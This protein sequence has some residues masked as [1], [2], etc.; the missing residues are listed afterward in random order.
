MSGEINV[1]VLM[2]FMA[3]EARRQVAATSNDLKVLG[4][5]AEEAGRKSTAAGQAVDQ[6]GASAGNAA[7]DIT[8]AGAAWSNTSTQAANAAAQMGRSAVSVAGTRDAITGLA[9]ASSAAVQ[10]INQMFSAMAS[11]ETAM[12][13]QIASLVGIKT[14]TEN[15]FTAQLRHGMMLDD[16]RAKFNPLFAATRQYEAYV[17]E[18]AEAEKFGA[19]SAEEA[20]AA[21]ERARMAMAKV[22]A[23]VGQYGAAVHQTSAHSANLF[24][25]WNDIA[26]MMAAGQNPMQLA[27]QQG[28]QVS[29]VLMQLGGGTKALRAVGSSFLAM[30]NPVSLATI[31]IIAFGAAGVKWLMSL[32]EETKN[33]DDAMGDLE[34]TLG[35]LERLTK[36]QSGS[37]AGLEETYGAITASV[38]E[39]IS[40]QV[41]LGRVKAE[42]SLQDARLAT[43][44]SAND[45]FPDFGRAEASG[46][47]GKTAMDRLKADMDSTEADVRKLIGTFSEL[48]N[49]QGPRA[50]ADAAAR[51]RKELL[52]V[53][54][55]YDALSPEQAQFFEEL[56]QTEAAARRLSAFTDGAN[57]SLSRQINEL[58]RGYTQ[59]AELAEISLRFGED[60]V[61]VEEARARQARQAL[62]IKLEDLGV[63]QDS[64]EA[65]DASAA[66]EAQ[67][68]ADADLAQQKRQKSQKEY[69]SDLGRQAELSIAIQ[70]YG[71][72]SA[73]VEAVRARHAQDV[74]Q[75]R[76]EEAHWLPTMVEEALKLTEA[77]RERA[78]AIKAAS[79]ARKA[80]DLLTT[81]REEADI[82]QAI[83]AYGEE[84]LQVKELQIASAKREFEQT[85]ATMQVT[86]EMKTQLRDAWDIARGMSAT[87]PF[88]VMSS[89]RDYL[90]DQQQ[91]I[92]QLKQEQ[93][94]LGQ[95]E[96]TRSRILTLWN[97]EMEIRKM[98]LD[99]TSARAQ[100]IRAAAIEE[101]ELTRTVERQKDAWTSVQSAAEDAIDGI[102]DKLM[103]GDFDGALED[104]ASQITGTLT[105]LAITNPL[106]NAMLGT[107]L[108][109]MG[110]VGGL[111]GIWARLMGKSD[112]TGIDPT[113]GFSTSSMAV[114][115]ANVTISTMGNL[116]L[117][118][119]GLGAA[120]TSASPSS[121]AGAGLNGG[122][123]SLSDADI[124]NLKK[125]VA[126]EWVQS[127]GDGQAAGIIDTI[128][129]RVASGK[130]GGTVAGV[131]NARSQFSDINGPVAWADGRSSVDDIPMTQISAKIDM[132]VD[133]W[134]R[135]RASGMS[136]SVGDHLS[137][138]N[139][140]YSDAAN[141]SWIN[142]LQGPVLGS[143]DASHLHGTPAWMQS[144]RPGAFGVSLPGS[145]LQD[146][147]STVLD[148]TQNLGTLGTGFDSFG[149]A[150]IQ[151][152]S[153]GG[154]GGSGGLLSSLMGPLLGAIGIPGFATG[155]V[156]SGGLRIVGENG[157][158][159]EYT[160]PSTILPTDLTRSIMTS[161]APNT[162]QASAPAIIQMQP[163][164]VNNTSVPVHVETEETVDSRGQRQQKYV[165]SELMST[166]ITTTGGKAQR[167][168]QGTYGLKRGGLRRE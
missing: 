28:T 105:E 78:N 41:E 50:T 133:N 167:S 13:R 46:H 48:E 64:K 19:I 138:A 126:T 12:Q 156:H 158:E 166:G 53:L 89:S 96:A 18:V 66:L 154:A 4:T 58:A 9:A 92:D 76:L 59:Q 71:E 95:Q 65:K 168:L 91:R 147:S 34:N 131:V 11:S 16:M 98:G 81:L 60:S 150:L 44:T 3:E 136:S 88:G 90:R 22:T 164:L 67:I 79:A 142:E 10:P 30:L 149:Q 37:A 84:S 86:E 38:R 132:V 8:T 112:A 97:A 26:V 87:D 20:T 114:N 160:G 49:A 33:F 75:A 103:G 14:A 101:A 7:S 157:P 135:Q 74:L 1:S 152:L 42:Q 29:Q 40:A 118:A 23:T 162:S 27:L 111:Q 69:F 116:G 119:T 24:A 83:L 54:G 80:D 56:T 77:E 151:A 73:E 5:S 43:S 93:S 155:G 32:K 31:G 129:N 137:Y 148:A 125:T 163:M 159:L 144:M 123:L 120:N 70:R 140:K 117:G 107:N 52:G 61:Q 110:D 143:G 153:G 128:L 146:F 165:I 35:D 108:G 2:R 130:W 82:N 104:M 124:I 68:S 121:Y 62:Q 113:S 15:A 94:L 139:P 63:E 100:E 122:V 25:Q 21:R 6:A 127:A 102:V 72:T 134:L 85:L 39:L 45:A 99:V 47:T 141:M 51:L 109:T 145:E 115:A 106:K 161:R 17:R 55:G 36:S 57:T